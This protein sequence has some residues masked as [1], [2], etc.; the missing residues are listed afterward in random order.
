LD[1]SDAVRDALAYVV[2]EGH[3]GVA[4]LPQHSGQKIAC[5]LG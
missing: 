5:V 4:D 2:P 3:R 1:L